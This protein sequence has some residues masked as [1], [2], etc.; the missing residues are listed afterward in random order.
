MS[1]MNA[2]L[3][4]QKSLLIMEDRRGQ[5]D[6]I[7]KN[8]HDQL[9]A[10]LKDQLIV[11][12]PDSRSQGDHNGRIFT[13]SA[14]REET[15][16][17]P[18]IEAH[19]NLMTETLPINLA[20]T[21]TGP[22]FSDLR[23]RPNRG[24]HTARTAA[25]TSPQDRQMVRADTTRGV[26]TRTP[27]RVPNSLVAT[28]DQPLSTNRVVHIKE[29]AKAVDHHLETLVLLATVIKMAPMLAIAAVLTSAHALVIVTALSVAQAIISNNNN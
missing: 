4:S 22:R 13:N 20:G 25:R 29:E 11:D 17:I 24:G 15:H 1:C 12:L 8:T 27:I 18:S 16:T 6:T 2:K 21:L 19:S 14:S 26:A 28:I 9:T 5:H 10:D 23:D 7:L 3:R